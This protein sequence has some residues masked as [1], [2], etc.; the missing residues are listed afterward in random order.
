MASFAEDSARAMGS[1]R[2]GLSFTP[3][4]TWPVGSSISL[5]FLVVCHTAS[6]SYP[7]EPSEVSKP[8]RKC[9]LL[10]ALVRRTSSISTQQ[11]YW[12]R[13]LIHLKGDSSLRSP[14]YV[15]GSPCFSMLLAL[16]AFCKATSSHPHHLWFHADNLQQVKI[17]KSGH[18]QASPA[19][20][21]TWERKLLPYSLSG[22]FCFEEL[23]VN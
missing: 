1:T 21:T 13:S 17:P 3:L 2:R 22:C 11:R 10:L 12:A 4:S 19:Q 14:W 20:Q 5:A 16:C 6:S 9:L 18:C 15:I 23:A 8:S 7:R